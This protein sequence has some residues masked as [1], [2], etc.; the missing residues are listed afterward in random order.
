MTLEK[1][2]RFREK[3][4]M[5]FPPEATDST[6]REAFRRFQVDIDNVV[7]HMNHVCCCCS[8]FVDSFQLE[9]FLDS[10]AVILSTFKTNIICYSSL[11][12]CGCCFETFN[13]GHEYWTHVSGGQE[14]KFGIYNKIS[15]LCCQH[16]ADLLEGLTST[17]KVVIARTHLVVSI[18]KLRPNNRFNPW[19]YRGICGHFMLLPQNQGSL[20]N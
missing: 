7:K 16:Y 17:K 5:A 12:I 4:Y 8:C 11:D 20:F 9:I 6:T 15:Q 19:S 2:F 1:N 18:L 13:F 3:A 10:D 14:P